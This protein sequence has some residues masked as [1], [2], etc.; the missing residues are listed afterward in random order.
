MPFI[1]PPV[2]AAVGTEDA[3]LHCKGGSRMKIVISIV[4]AMAFLLAAAIATHFSSD[5]MTGLVV[6]DDPT[7]GDRGS[8]CRML[9]ERSN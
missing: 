1:G 3:D 2:R 4:I 9:S 6:C 7:S 8:S 5:R